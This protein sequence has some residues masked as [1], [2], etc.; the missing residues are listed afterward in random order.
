MQYQ[1]RLTF[2]F[3][4]IIFLSIL[5][6]ACNPD[7]KIEK[8][9]DKEIPKLISQNKVVVLNFWAT[10]CQ[11]CV[12]EIPIFVKLHQQHPKI[13]IVGI[14]MDEADQL[15][16][17]EEFAKKHDM[18]YKIVLRVGEN[19]ETMVNTIDPSWMGGLPATFVFKDGRR[20]FSKT[21]IITE[22]ELLQAIQ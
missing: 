15:P 17:V 3:L 13:E 11:P 19:F 22:Q 9:D 6:A 16:A 5:I 7:R 10:W 1:T 14:S 2:S 21:G 8:L 18:D 4:A 12:E 20:T